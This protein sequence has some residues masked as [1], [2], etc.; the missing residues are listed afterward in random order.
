MRTTSPEQ[1]NNQT[2]H[3]HSKKC[4][5]TFYLLRLGGKEIQWE[6]MGWIFFWYND[7]NLSDWAKVNAAEQECVLGSWAWTLPRWEAPSTD[8]TF[9]T[10]RRERR[11]PLWAGVVILNLFRFIFSDVAANTCWASVQ[12]K[13]QVLLVLMLTNGD[14]RPF[15]A[16]IVWLSSQSLFDKGHMTPVC[17]WH[18]LHLLLSPDATV[19]EVAFYTVIS[20][21]LVQW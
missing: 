14:S 7:I 1:P 5:N 11:T 16:P 9:C 2:R 10:G 12:M 4:F 21:G 15:S 13:M 20:N 8:W 19:R 18:S 3:H 6:S 17:V